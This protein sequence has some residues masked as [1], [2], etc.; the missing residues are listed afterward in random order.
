MSETMDLER[1]VLER[2]E[3]DELATIA[4]ALG[5]KPG[6]R[7][8]KETLIDQILRGAGVGTS[9]GPSSDIS[10]DAVAAKPKR[11]TRA[12][13]AVAE[14]PSAGATDEVREP[15]RVETVSAPSN[16]P[17]SAATKMEESTTTPIAVLWEGDLPHIERRPHQPR[18]PP[19]P[20]LA[21]AHVHSTTAPHPAR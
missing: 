10:T 4:G 9:A 20:L 1:S 6:A 5:M 7:A 13:K 15:A 21:S 18:K 14:P 12:R 19:H 17:R 2:K 16:R 8:K 3:R 11:V